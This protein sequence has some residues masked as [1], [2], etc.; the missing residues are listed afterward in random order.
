MPML[1]LTKEEL[2]VHLNL[3]ETLASFQKS[4]R[5][6]LENVRGAT[7]DE[8]FRGS[9]LGLRSPG[10][11]LPG[12]ISAGTFR[13]G[14]DRQ[15]AFVTRGTHPVVIELTHERWARIILGVTDARNM[16]IRINAAV[17]KR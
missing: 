7:D 3:W 2:I 4:I 13:K 9:A 10:T 12:I 11:G 17:E 8:G 16:A 15:F 14:G 6:P 5:I 1:E